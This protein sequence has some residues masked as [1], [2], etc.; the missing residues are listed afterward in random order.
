MSNLRKKAL[1]GVVMSKDC[2][3]V[4]S[5]AFTEAMINGAGEIQAGLIAD[6]AVSDHWSRLVD[7]GY[8]AMREIEGEDDS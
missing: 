2:K 5:E 7:N 6:D 1:G 4:W 8:D 3:E